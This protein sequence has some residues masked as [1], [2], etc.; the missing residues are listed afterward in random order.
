MISNIQRMMKM[1]QLTFLNKARIS[2]SD[3]FD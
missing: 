2:G 1:S 3:A